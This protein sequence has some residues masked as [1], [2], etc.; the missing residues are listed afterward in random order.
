MHLNQPLRTTRRRPLAAW[1]GIFA[2][3]LP[4]LAPVA[5]G[6]PLAGLSDNAETPFFP[7]I[8]K[9]MQE[10]P[11]QPPG[12]SPDLLDCPVCLGFSFGNSVLI[13]PLASQ[14]FPTVR[15]LAFILNPGNE[16]NNGRTVSQAHA[17]APPLSA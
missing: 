4:M 7:F 16:S 2:L 8:C 9:A 10:D 6:I 1:L 13:T 17:R 11:V 15:P 3:V 5:Q 14:S 12:Q